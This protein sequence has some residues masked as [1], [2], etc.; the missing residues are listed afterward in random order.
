MR[1]AAIQAAILDYLRLRG[2]FFFRC[3]TGA[4]Q[5]QPGWFV[6]FGIKGAPDIIGCVGGKFVGLE[7]TRAGSEDA[8]GEAVG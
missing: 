2:R 1:E 3:N 7:V 5:A 8:E 4:F 6:R